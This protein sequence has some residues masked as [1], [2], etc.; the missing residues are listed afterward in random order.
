MLSCQIGLC[1]IFEQFVRP[2]QS[3]L[4]FIDPHSKHCLI[5]KTLPYLVGIAL[6]AIAAASVYEM[7]RMIEHP[8]VVP[9]TQSLAG[10]DSQQNQ[11]PGVPEIN[12]RMRDRIIQLKKQEAAHRQ[13]TIVFNAGVTMLTALAALIATITTVRAVTKRRS[14]I[15]VAVLTFCSTLLNYGQS[16]FATEKDEAAR[17]TEQI[18]KWRLE[19]ESLPPK[20]LRDQL[21]R[22]NNYLDEL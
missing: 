1:E 9:T 10:F 3:V 20:D 16:H 14:T 17:K 8:V 2:R 11:V 21:E 5:V 15:L 4:A 13:W 12:Q 19:L 7:Y 22:Y 18:K 6:L